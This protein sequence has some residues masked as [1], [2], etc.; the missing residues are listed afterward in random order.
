MNIVAIGHRGAKGLYKDNSVRS[1]LSAKLLDLD[2]I[3][4][5][6]QLT[7]DDIFI[8]YHDNYIQSYFIENPKEICDIEYSELL[9]E[10]I[11][12]LN[13]G[14]GY[15]LTGEPCVPYLDLK[16]PDSKLQDEKYMKYYGDRLMEFLMEDNKETIFLASFHKELIDYLMSKKCAH[17]FLF[18][19][20]YEKG[21]IPTVEQLIKKV[22]VYVFHYEDAATEVDTLKFVY[23]V[24]EEDDIKKM[25]ELGVD[26]IVS[27]YPQKV[28]SLR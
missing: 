16:I 6:V 24:N 21:E 27:D 13:K 12:T 2:M 22:D 11:C 10:D 9:A 17:N 8:L 20:I 25:V 1:I 14:L 4:I 28:V 5:D 19:Y 26:G 15:I 18:G 3:E 23:T 7:K